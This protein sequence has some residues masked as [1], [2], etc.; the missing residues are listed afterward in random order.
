MQ[1]A[2]VVVWYV[3]GFGLVAVAPT[4]STRRRSLPSNL[5][6]IVTPALALGLCAS[7]SKRHS[8]D[9]AFMQHVRCV[10]Y[11]FILAQP[12]LATVQ[13]ACTS[14]PAFRHTDYLP[15]LDCVTCSA[16]HTWPHRVVRW[17]ESHRRKH[18]RGHTCLR[19]ADVYLGG[20][21]LDRALIRYLEMVTVDFRKRAINSHADGRAVFICTACGPSVVNVVRCRINPIAIHRRQDGL[22]QLSVRLIKRN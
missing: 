19:S 6:M 1:N 10:E 13:R 20:S 5:N 16:S 11:D 22:V 15:R 2:C 9:G 4:W 17:N 21:V 14:R 7:I 3:H 12:R 18:A 8:S